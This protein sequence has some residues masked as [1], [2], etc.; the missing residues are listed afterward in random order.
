MSAYEISN[1]F[2]PLYALLGTLSTNPANEP[3]ETR[4]SPPLDA[5]VP[6]MTATVLPVEIVP[7][8]GGV[9]GSVGELFLH[10]L[11]MNKPAIT[12]LSIHTFFM[13]FPSIRLMSRNQTVKI[14]SAF[15]HGSKKYAFL[16]H[17]CK[18]RAL[19]YAPGLVKFT[20]SVMTN[21]YAIFRPNHLQSENANG[22]NDTMIGLH[23]HII[24]SAQN[25]S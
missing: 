2:V 25:H 10:A 3:V 24:T 5:I 1:D 13:L 22:K 21:W 11:N 8:V 16:S 14:S 7:L 19:N 15:T 17:A 4:N 18:F 20:V 12:A 6:L 23:G 9:L